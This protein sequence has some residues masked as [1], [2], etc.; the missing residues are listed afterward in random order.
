LVSL[1][2]GA[3]A[4]EAGDRF[5]LVVDPNGPTQFFD[6]TGRH[7]ILLG[8]VAD[9]DPGPSVVPGSVLA[10]SVVSPDG[11]NAALLSGGWLEITTSNPSFAGD[12][13]FAADQDLTIT[14]WF[15]SAGNGAYQATPSLGRYSDRMHAIGFGSDTSNL[16]VDFG[17]EDAVAGLS[18]TACWTYFTG[19]GSN[20][21]VDPNASHGRNYY[22]D[23]AWHRYTLVRAS[24]LVTVYMDNH[25]L[26][27]IAYSGALGSDSPSA[28]NY[29]GRASV[30]Y[31]SSEDPLPW[32]GYIAGVRVFDEALP[33]DTTPP[34]LSCPPFVVVVDR[35]S[36]L[37]APTGEAVDYSVTAADAKDPAPVVVCTP[38]S[39]SFFP[40]GTTI[41]ICTAM[42][43]SG[44]QSSCMFPVSVLPKARQRRL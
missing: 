2:L 38:P 19:S 42:D 22:L 41:V 11:D 12:F 31:I 5:H 25:L 28:R 10:T 43:A 26:G 17:D 34:V 32:F 21:V 24:A 7:G 16:D 18:E 15:K 36:G 8:G 27:T 29:I 20:N 30:L 1:F 6:A 13:L 3:T 37:P 39:G 23:D 14:F 40:V 9:V 44:N 33:P 35:F 4:V